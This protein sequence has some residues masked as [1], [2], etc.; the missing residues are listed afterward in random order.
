MD[1][2]DG[3]ICVPCQGEAT[4][5]SVDSDWDGTPDCIDLCPLDASKTKPGLCG[6]GKTEEDW[7]MDGDGVIDCLDACPMNPY[8]QTDAGICG[9]E[10]NPADETKDTD[11][12][13]IPDCIDACPVNSYQASNSACGCE[14]PQINNVYVYNISACDPKTNTFT[15]D[16]AVYFDYPPELGGIDFRGDLNFYHNFENHNTQ[17][18]LVFPYRTFTADGGSID[19]IVEYRGNEGCNFMAVNVGKAPAACQT[20]NIP[21]PVSNSTDGVSDPNDNIPIAGSSTPIDPNDIIPV[22]GGGANPPPTTGSSSS[23]VVVDASGSTNCGIDFIGI[24]NVRRCSDNR[25]RFKTSDDYFECDV[26]IK[27]NNPPTEGMLKMTGA[28]DAW[29]DVRQLAGRDRFMMQGVRLPANG[30]PFELGCAFSHGNQCAHVQKFEGISLQGANNCNSCN[31]MSMRVM[32]MQCSGDLMT[33]DL[34]VTGSHT[35]S[36][37]KLNGATGTYTGTYNQPS[38]FTCSARGNLVLEIIDDHNPSCRM[39][40][41]VNSIACAGGRSNGR[42]GDGFTLNNFLN[43]APNPAQDELLVEFK[44]PTLR[45]ISDTHLVIYDLLGKKQLERNVTDHRA[46]TYLDISSLQN[47]VYMITLNMDGLLYTG[48]L[49]KENWK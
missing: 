14:A 44:I 9:C 31:V 6:C 7:D 39:P 47:G 41:E 38:R 35:A 29:I 20:V 49:V 37:Y 15:A 4:A 5:G 17:T 48:K 33:F 30:Q 2:C 21:V 24:E 36:T 34:M 13:G 8:K 23:P 18:V 1:E 43:Y 45:D 19:F 10:F 42:A 16:V 46:K 26:M 22:P 3:S 32:N 11:K 27:Y 12:D 40:F 25:T 28:S